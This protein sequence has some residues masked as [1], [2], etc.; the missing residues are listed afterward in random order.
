MIRELHD[1]SVVVLR[2]CCEGA[3]YQ[4]GPTVPMFAATIPFPSSL[5]SNGWTGGPFVSK[6]LLEHWS[7]DAKSK[8][9]ELSPANTV[10]RLET[11]PRS[12][13]TRKLTQ[14]LQ[15]FNEISLTQYL[16]C[17]YLGQQ[18]VVLSNPPDNTIVDRNLGRSR[19]QWPS[20]F[21]NG[22]ITRG[23]SATAEVH[24]FQS[25]NQLPPRN[26]TTVR[27]GGAGLR[28]INCT[29]LRCLPIRSQFF[30]LVVPVPV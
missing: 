26:T 6:P 23:S 9:N 3:R 11:I 30:R 29:V 5:A 22:P 16:I 4:Q 1:G 25:W 12:R 8:T 7:N 24:D 17:M 10:L 2:G 21:T 14:K 27:H 13:W 15:I 19:G 28:A 20:R 18:P